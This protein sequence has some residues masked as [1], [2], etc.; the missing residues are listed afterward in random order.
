VLIHTRSESVPRPST[1]FHSYYFLEPSKAS[2][3]KVSREA[4][5]FFFNSKLHDAT[6]KVV[7][8]GL[9]D[10]TFRELR[11]MCEA[12]RECCLSHHHHPLVLAL[13]RNLLQR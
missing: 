10:C 9:L 3:T 11:F 1:N 8:K 2:V 13:V 6:S 12:S 7:L 4:V 5:A